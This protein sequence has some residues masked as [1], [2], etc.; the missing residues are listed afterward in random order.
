MVDLPVTTEMVDFVARVV[1]LAAIGKLE[2]EATADESTLIAP[3]G[4]PYTAKLERST[5]EDDEGRS[6]TVV[7]LALLK[8]R[9]ELFRVYPGALYGTTFTRLLATPLSPMEVFSDLWNRAVVKAA[10]VT[11]ELNV[12]NRLLAER[13]D[14][15]EDVPF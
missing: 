2:W 10:K 5:Y 9:Q 8:S 1:K 15:E 3:L 12:V 13:L 11:D 4:G 14:E 7:E 6:T